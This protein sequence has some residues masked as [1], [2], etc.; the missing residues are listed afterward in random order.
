MAKL[1]LNQL[2]ANRIEHEKK[3]TSKDISVRSLGGE[4]TFEK[5]PNEVLLDLMDKVGDGSNARDA[6]QAFRELIYDSC[7]M[8]KSRELHEEYGIKDPYDIVD[9]LFDL[10]DI[11]TVGTQLLEMTGLNAED[12]DIKIK[13]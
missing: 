4:L 7:Q 8:L 11:V 5:P 10:G 3:R 6:I 1:T 9:A 13:N 2:I 12:L